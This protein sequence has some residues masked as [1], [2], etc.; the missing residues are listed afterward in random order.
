[1]VSSGTASKPIAMSIPIHQVA[2][3]GLD[4]SLN[5]EFRG[6]FSA[7]TDSFDRH[8]Q[9]QLSPRSRYGTLNPHSP[10]N[11][12]HNSGNTYH[13]HL[14]V[15]NIE[16]SMDS[17]LEDSSNVVRGITLLRATRKLLIV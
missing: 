17:S 3:P 16:D 13:V 9:Q 14:E 12:P 1:M 2:S 8:Y 6:P 15:P 7:P 5:H 4:D 11:A 10:Y